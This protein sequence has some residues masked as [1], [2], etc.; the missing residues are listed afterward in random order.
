MA[1]GAEVARR[2]HDVVA[3]YTDMAVERVDGIEASYE[4]L[5]EAAQ[6]LPF[7][8]EHKLI[9]LRSPGGNKEF[10]EQFESFAAQVPATN[11]V[12]IVE[13]KLDKRLSY[14]KQL[15]KL[16]DFHEFAELDALSLAKWAVSYVRDQGGN[17]SMSDAQ[18]LIQR[19]GDVQHTNKRTGASQLLA[20]HELDKL[21]VYDTAVTRKSIDLLTDQTPSGQIF[22]MLDAALGGD[23]ARTLALYQDQRAQQI[24]PQKILA[25]LIWQMYIVALTKTGQTKTADEIARD[26]SM[27]PYAISK[28][29]AVAR[30]MSYARLRELVSGLRDIDE[31][32]KTEAIN[33]DDAVQFY[34]LSLAAS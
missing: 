15:R 12:L 30:R 6:S 17:I 26:T 34:L 24:E 4:R 2:V 13:P 1:R 8:V 29:S 7:L 9:V 22:D 18:Y 31:R 5:C 3:A 10:V 28:A 23:M 16:T 20:Q 33:A 27:K 25:M 14:Y 32:L 11:D 21:L 19:I